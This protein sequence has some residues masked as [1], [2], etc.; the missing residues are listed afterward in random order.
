MKLRKWYFKILIS[1]RKSKV[2][3]R[4]AKIFDN[5]TDF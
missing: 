1:L 5:D 3:M 4:R 2:N